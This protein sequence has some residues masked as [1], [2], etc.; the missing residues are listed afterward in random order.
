MQSSRFANRF[1][2][3][4]MV[5]L[6]KFGQLRDRALIVDRKVSNFGLITPD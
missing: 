4:G 3:H 1:A 6:R 5:V 2:I